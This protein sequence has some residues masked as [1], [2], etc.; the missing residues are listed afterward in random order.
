MIINRAVLRN[1]NLPENIVFKIMRKAMK[2]KQ[3]ICYDKMSLNK[4]GSLCATVHFKREDWIKSQL[5]FMKT[6]RFDHVKSIER[7]LKIV[8]GL[9]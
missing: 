1:N 8:E 6:L 5:K 4:R 2:F 7:V 3:Q 9:R